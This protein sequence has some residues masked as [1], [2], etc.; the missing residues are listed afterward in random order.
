MFSSPSIQFS[1]CG[2]I[3]NLRLQRIKVRSSMKQLLL[4]VSCLP[5]PVSS[6]AQTP[7]TFDIATYQPPK[8]WHR[9]AS[10]NSIQIS[11]EDKASGTY[12]MITLLK[13][14]PGTN[15]SRENFDAAW[16]TVVKGMVNV[17]AAPQMASPGNENGWEIQSGVAAFEKNGEKGL[18][19]LVT[20]SSFSRMVNVVIL[21]NTQAY[22]QNISDFLGSITLKKPV[23]EIVTAPPRNAPAV[24]SP[25]AST[26]GY[27]LPPPILMMDG[28]APFRKIGCMLPKAISEF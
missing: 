24:S 9:Q 23:A 16:Q 15:S 4:I 6:L 13:S 5:F 19:M 21:T 12:C 27:F 2:T 14:V 25:A 28:Q 18:A 17:S 11:T 1:Q 26:G 8:S 22:Q 7:E 3:D 20:A 10:Q